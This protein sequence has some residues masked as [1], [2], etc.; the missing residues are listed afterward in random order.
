MQVDVTGSQR[1]AVFNDARGMNEDDHPRSNGERQYTLH[2]LPGGKAALS[3]HSAVGAR[4]RALWATDSCSCPPAPRSGAVRCTATPHACPACLPNPNPN[5]S[6][7]PSPNPTCVPRYASVKDQMTRHK[8]S[9]LWKPDEQ[10]DALAA[11]PAPAPASARAA[12]RRGQASAQDRPP[13]GG[14]LSLSARAPFTVKPTAASSVRALQ[15]HAAEG[16][17]YP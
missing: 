12:R 13:H 16:S 9:L 8:L 15:A 3:R 14:G 10:P 4:S 5:P 17:P 6:P 2:H 1:R 11:T 7:N